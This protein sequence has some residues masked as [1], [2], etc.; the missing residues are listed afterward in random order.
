MIAI[1][2]PTLADL[3]RRL[4]AAE[5][6]LPA[7]APLFHAGDKVQV[8]H[9]V[10]HGEAH[11]V[12]HQA[13][14]AALIL[15]RAGPGTMLAEASLHAERYHCAA[16]AATA[17]RLRRIPRRVLRAAI[18]ADPALA[19]AWSA[20]LAREVQSARLR[21]EILA[22]RG[23]AARLD[24][25]LAWHAALPPRGAW[26]ALAG[27]LAVSPEALYREIARRRQAPPPPPSPPSPPP[28]PP[29]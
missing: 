10:L 8:M 28:P 11:L 15:Q 12:R 7:G 6:A 20:H 25:W 5:S 13:N 9:L 4:Q 22:L 24:A 26:R 16:I 19:A 27:E 18:A 2:S 29:A 1:M 23:V 14:G 21:A 3:L 17:L